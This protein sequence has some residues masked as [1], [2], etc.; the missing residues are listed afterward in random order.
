VR[1]LR[2]R[3]EDEAAKAAS[4]GASSGSENGS[5]D[6]STD[7]GGP[8]VRGHTA[9]KGRPTPKRRDAETRRRGPAPPP[10]KTQ[11][12]SMKLA[13][14]NRAARK[15]R[16]ESMGDRR[17]RM[18]AGDQKALPARDRGPVK[19][20]VRDLVDSRHHLMGFFM[21]LALVV[22][23]SLFLRIPAVQSMISLF[24]I[25]M[26]VVMALEGVLLGRRVARAARAKF[27][28]EQISTPGLGWY[29]FSRASQI[30]RLRVPK[31]RVAIGDTV[32]HPA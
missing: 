9:G 16:R 6:G 23:V 22:F 21:P 29:A 20:Y 15:E 17:A 31:P 12:E 2:R 13:R 5:A 30:R 3:S 19:A 10:P 14:A 26:M 4:V 1:F 28:K 8:A 18:L 27:P 32:D 25:A 24:V 7:P 11:R